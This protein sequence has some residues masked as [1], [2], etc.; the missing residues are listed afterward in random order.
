MTYEQFATELIKRL[1]AIDDVCSYCD[2]YKPNDFCDEYKKTGGN[3]DFNVCRDNVKKFI[4]KLDALATA[5]TVYDVT[6][7]VYQIKTTAKPGYDIPA[8]IKS[9]FAAL[10]ATDYGLKH[11]DLNDLDGVLDYLYGGY[12]LLGKAHYKKLIDFIEA[13]CEV[14]R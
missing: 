11:I 2:E 5:Q 6:K 1:F 13:R 10:Y 9:E 7:A 8:L 3:M 14:K 12:K 4:E